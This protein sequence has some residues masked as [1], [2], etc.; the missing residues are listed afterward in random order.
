MTNDIIN[1]LRE[2]VAISKVVVKSALNS[3]LYIIGLVSIPCFIIAH[4]SSSPF[5]WVF[6]VIGCLPILV[7][8]FGFLYLLL[9]KHRDY[10]RSEEF[11]IQKFT[12]EYLGQKGKELTEGQINSLTALAKPSAYLTKS[13]ED[14]Q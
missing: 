6:I 1:L 5:N 7:T 14:E 11:H 9:S 10:L 4:F 12:L 3:I 13:D 2:N 8:C